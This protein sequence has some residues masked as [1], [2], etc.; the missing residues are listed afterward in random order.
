MSRFKTCSVCNSPFTVR[1]SYQVQR[2]VDD[3]FYFCS[4]DCHERHLSSEAIRTCSV[5]QKEFNHVYYFQQVNVNGHNQYFCSEECRRRPS[6]RPRAR[7][8]ALKKIAV[9]NQKGGTGKTTTSIFMSEK[10]WG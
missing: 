1:F 9:L 2:T 7:Q 8:Y 4:Q 6:E 10:H 3:T 5:C